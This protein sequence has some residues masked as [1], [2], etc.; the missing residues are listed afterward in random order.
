MED[1]FEKTE[2][3]RDE[4]LDKL[5]SNIK[6]IS[7]K[8]NN[9]SREVEKLKLSGFQEQIDSQNDK[10]NKLENLNLETCRHAAFVDIENLRYNFRVWIDKNLAPNST[11]YRNTSDFIE[12]TFAASREALSF[13]TSPTII[14]QEFRGKCQDYCKRH[15]IPAFLEE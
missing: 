8:I 2:F 6:K 10:L 7:G 5:E 15:N 13:S 4:R 12:R 9:L 3:R 1:D 11:L 14:A